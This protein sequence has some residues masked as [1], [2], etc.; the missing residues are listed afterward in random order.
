MVEPL[1]VFTGRSFNSAMVCGELFISTW[2]SS[3]PILAEPEGVIRFCELMALTMSAGD[4][5][6]ACS[7]G[8]SRSTCTCRILPP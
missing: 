6:F 8:M 5:P 4:N 2:Y 1:T 3:G 7:L